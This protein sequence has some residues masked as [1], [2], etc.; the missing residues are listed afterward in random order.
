MTEQE[1]KIKELEDYIKILQ[2]R[3]DENDYVNKHINVLLFRDGDDNDG[4]Y[5]E[6]GKE[7]QNNK[8]VLVC[9]SNRVEIDKGSI[10]VISDGKNNSISNS[11]NS[12]II[13]TDKDSNTTFKGDTIIGGSS[14]KIVNSS[15]CSIGN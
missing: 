10:S 1:Q 5:I 15:N 13:S 14:N 9:G 2:R 12:F 4:Y 3:I 8:I 6:I 7:R 11:E